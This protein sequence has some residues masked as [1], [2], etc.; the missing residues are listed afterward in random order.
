M[1]YPSR[2]S[3]TPSL[4]TKYAIFEGWFIYKPLKKWLKR[5]LNICCSDD[6]PNHEDSEGM[7][8]KHNDIVSKEL[9]RQEYEPGKATPTIDEQR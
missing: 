6:E 3:A 4:G 9:R 2:P 8:E 7:I 5:V 1:V